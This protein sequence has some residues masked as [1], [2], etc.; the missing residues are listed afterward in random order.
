M[1][2]I[3]ASAL[4]VASIKELRRFLKENPD[5][6]FNSLSR[7]RKTLA[8]AADAP[9][10]EGCTDAEETRKKLQTVEK[11]MRLRV[12]DGVLVRRRKPGTGSKAEVEVEY[13]DTQTNRKA[14]RVG[15]KYTKIVYQDGEV[16]ESARKM[17]KRKRSTKDEDGTPVPKRSNLWIQAVQQA[18]AELG[19][20]AFLIIRREAK[21][22][23][24]EL[25]V[26]GVKVYEKARENMA[27]LKQAA[28]DAAAAAAAAAEPV[29]A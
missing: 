21:D 7:Y 14:G 4:L 6:S 25:D 19:A 12:K 9:P 8:V 28:A 17:R 22:P 1:G 26:I 24:N 2:K 23:A 18:K 16:E 10:C 13:K 3:T 15:L 20:P 29:A 11:L 27:L 5:V